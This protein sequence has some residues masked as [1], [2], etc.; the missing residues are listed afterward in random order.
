MRHHIKHRPEDKGLALLLRKLS[1]RFAPEPPF[2]D[3]LGKKGVWTLFTHALRH[4]VTEISVQRPG[5]ITPWR[6]ALVADLHAGGHAHDLKRLAGIMVDVDALQPDAV[7]LL[8]DY[9]NMMGFGGGRIPP[10]A[11]AAILKFPQAKHGAFA[12]LGNHDWDYGFDVV[13]AALEGHGIE[14][15]E[16][17]VT[18]LVR[19]SETLAL[20]GLSD[21]RCGKPDPSLIAHVPAGEAMV[22]LAHD[23]ATFFDVPSGHLMVSGHMHGGQIRVPGMLPLVVPA[24]RAPRRWAHGHIKERGGDLIVSAGLGCSGLPI[25]IGIRPE[26]VMLT[27]LPPDAKEPV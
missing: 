25:R 14:V 22:L 20:V 17:Q 11:I 9:M 12:V 21:D 5:I 7:L 23:P 2:H 10:D 8:G 6:L 13:R 26:I 15:L 24:G 18:T 3:R 4:R 27:L 1:A 16:N 19:G